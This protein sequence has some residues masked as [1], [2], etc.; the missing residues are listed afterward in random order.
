MGVFVIICSILNVIIIIGCFFATL[1]IKNYLPS[2]IDEKGKNLATKED[3]KEITLKTEEVQKEFKENFEIFTSDVHFKYDYYYKQYCE[4]YSEIYGIIIQSEYVRY[5][6]KLS[7]DKN[8]TFE[9]A[10]FLEVSK[11]HRTTTKIEWKNGE[12]AK[13]TQ[14]SEDISTPISE[15]NKMK[16]CE[17][18]IQKSY[19]AS[20]ELL[21]LAVSYRYANTYYA[22]NESGKHYSI[23][24]TANEEEFRLIRELVCCIVREYNFLRKELKMEF[25]EKEL[26]SGIIQL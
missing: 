16:L 26:N 10:P 4:L 21:K 6:M 14:H 11:S 23:E 13:T 17:H 9:E 1:I 22:G 8:I 15:F 5:F 2:Y 7:D 18:I 12:E 20:P 3:I 24:D 25:N 19:V